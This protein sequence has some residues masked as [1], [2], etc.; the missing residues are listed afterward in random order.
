MF[1]DVVVLLAMVVFMEQLS[2]TMPPMMNGAPILAQVT[3]SMLFQINSSFASSSLQW[4]SLSIWH[5]LLPLFCRCGS[6]T[7]RRM[8]QCACHRCCVKFSWKNCPSCFLW[9]K[10]DRPRNHQKCARWCNDSW[11][12]LAIQWLNQHCWLRWLRSQV[13]GMSYMRNWTV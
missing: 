8:N 6:I 11:W 3:Q 10:Y 13:N 12:K 4:A 1:L 7:R 5:H 9:T 2:S